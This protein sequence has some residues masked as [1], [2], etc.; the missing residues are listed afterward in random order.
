[1][2]NHTRRNIEFTTKEAAE[3]N[4][5]ASFAFQRFAPSLA[6]C[7]CFLGLKRRA[8]PFFAVY[9]FARRGLLESSP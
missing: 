5:L 9:P 3:Q 2:C 4:S 8:F 6:G 1:V 7:Y